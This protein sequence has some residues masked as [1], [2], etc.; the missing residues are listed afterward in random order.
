MKKFFCLAALLL[1]RISF[2]LSQDLFKQQ[3][4]TDGV[5]V[6]IGPKSTNDWVDG[7]STVIIG[8]ND[9]FMVDANLVPK[10]SK[11]VVDF[12]QQTTDK[13]VKYVL[14]THWHYDHYLGASSVKNAYPDAEIIAHKETKRLTLNNV[15]RYLEFT[16]GTFAAEMD[17]VRAELSRGTKA[18][19]T[20]LTQ[21]EKTRSEQSIKDADF[22]LPALKEASFIPASITFNSELDI[23]LGNREVQILHYGRG[24]TPGDAFA[25][26]PAEK[27]LITGDLLVH[28]IPY[29]FG[30]YP[31]E[32][33][34]TLKKMSLLDADVIIPGHGEV[35]YNK[36]YL[37][38]VIS[39]LE[40]VTLQVSKLARD[41]KS[42]DEVKKE[43]NF[44]TLKTKMAGDDEDRKWAFENYFIIPIIPRVYDEAKGR[45]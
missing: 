44:E 23:S 7:N 6:F 2:T 8:D 29:A 40:E 28:P 12:I 41:G 42:L 32:W 1:F 5:F 33:I 34:A 17:T 9:V 18:D 45:L 3:K 43:V 10:T 4:I 26:L 39:A 36:D 22:Y 19:G 38:L 31:T 14:V 30:C 11:Q 16:I 13:P 37:L 21:Y 20:P 35:Q 25:Y 27:V 15:K 24:N